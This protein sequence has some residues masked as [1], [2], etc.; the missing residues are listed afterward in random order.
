MASAIL[1]LHLNF[2]NINFWGGTGD[3]VVGSR[4]VLARAG[5]RRVSHTGEVRELAIVCICTGRVDGEVGAGGVDPGL[6][7]EDTSVARVVRVWP[8]AFGG[9]QVAGTT[10]ITHEPDGGPVSTGARRARQHDA[11]FNVTALEAELVPGLDHAGAKVF[12]VEL[13]LFESNDHGSV[14]GVDGFGR[15]PF[16]VSGTRVPEIYGL[17]VRIVTGPEGSSV[18]LELVTEYEMVGRLVVAASPLEGALRGIGIDEG[19]DGK[20]RHLAGTVGTTE[21]KGALGVIV[22]DVLELDENRVAEKEH[23]QAKCKEGEGEDIEEATQVPAVGGRVPFGVDRV[24]IVV[25]LLCK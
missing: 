17:P 16:V 13:V 23:E 1:G 7:G 3:V 22:V 5:A 24:E 6:V 15:V 9:G 25:L 14:G 21:T 12:V 4:V 2:E 20:G 11:E 19:R 10:E 18:D 8:S